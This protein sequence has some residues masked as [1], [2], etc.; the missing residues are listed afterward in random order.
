MRAVEADGGPVDLPER[1]QLRREEPVES[2][3][4]VGVSPAN[5]AYDVRGRERGGSPKRFAFVEVHDHDQR[6]TAPRPLPCRVT[7]CHFVPSRTV[8]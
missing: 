3:L 6:E 8:S 4:A 1:V 5:S 2:V 7:R